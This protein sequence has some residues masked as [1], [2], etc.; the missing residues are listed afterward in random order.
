MALLEITNLTVEFATAHGSLRAVDQV[1]L[2]LDAGDIVVALGMKHTR[3]GDTVVVP[4]KK[5]NHEGR[6]CRHRTRGRNQSTGGPISL[7]DVCPSLC[8][9]VTAFRG[10]RD[11]AC[12]FRVA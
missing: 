12:V 7:P 4:A 3:T 8:T 5:G 6:K 2:S 11:A 9:S 10:P 1:S